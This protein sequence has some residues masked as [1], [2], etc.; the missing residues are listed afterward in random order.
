M[1]EKSLAARIARAIV[2]LNFDEPEEAR[3]V[4]LEALAYLNFD[5]PENR[6]EHHGNATA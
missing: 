5:M 4:L 3:D 2:H 6:K 1:A